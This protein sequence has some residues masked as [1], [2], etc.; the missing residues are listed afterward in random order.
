[1][2][3]QKASTRW[4]SLVVLIP[5]ALSSYTHLWN[6]GGFPDMFYD[7]GAYLRRA[8]NIL[9]YLEPQESETYYDHPYFGQ[10]LLAGLFAASGFPDSSSP[11]LESV[12]SLYTL[13]KIWMG[14]FSVVDTFLIY[15]IVHARY[16]HRRMA[17]LASL[18]FAVMPISWLTRRVLLESLLLPFML[19]SILLAIYMKKSTGSDRQYLLM[20]MSGT[21]MGLAIFTKVPALAAIPLVSFLVYSSTG[22][23]AKKVGLWLIPV[24]LIPLLWPLHSISE[25]RF[26]YWLSSLLLQTQ[27]SSDGIAT[28]FW[29]FWKID[30]VLLI[31]GSVGLVYSILIKRDYFPILWV[32]PFLVLYSLVGYVQY[33]HVIPLLPILCITSTLLSFDVIRHLWPTRATLASIGIMISLV[34]FGLGVTTL[35]ITTDMTSSQYEAAAFVLAIS[36]DNTTIVSNPTYSWLY[37][38]VL[39]RPN[40]LTDYRDALYSPLPT[41][42]VVLVSEPHFQA[43]IR[44]GMQL[45][46]MYDRTSSVRVFYGQIRNYDVHSYPYSSLSVT[47]QGE[48]IDVRQSLAP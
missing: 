13:P 18:L 47:G 2:F 23:N 4:T 46:K 19:A 39:Y 6:A 14:L 26:D 3:I 1:M 48:L 33:F 22:N 24:I 36:D 20:A 12:K 34:V 9:Y 37:N 29:N 15:K 11:T 42:D 44:E 7:E 45:E 41:D 5:I 17:M 27:R 10:I 8:M 40:A 35:V 31:L 38:F 43:N 16:E 21:C 30:P 32:L 25:E 28:I